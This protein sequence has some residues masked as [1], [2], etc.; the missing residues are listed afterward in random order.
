MILLGFNRLQADKF[1][2][3]LRIESSLRT[4]TVAG[5]FPVLLPSLPMNFNRRSLIAEMTTL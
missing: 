5:C 2:G 1:H 4:E 3:R